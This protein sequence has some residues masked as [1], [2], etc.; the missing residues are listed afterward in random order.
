[1]TSL[2]RGSVRGWCKIC[3]DGEM[4]RHT[5]PLV[6]LPSYRGYRALLLRLYPREDGRP[7][8]RECACFHFPIKAN[9]ALTTHTPSREA[10][11]LIVGR[12]LPLEFTWTRIS[13]GPIISN[14][15]YFISINSSQTVD[16]DRSKSFLFR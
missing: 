5:L 13:R 4:K 10:C 3:F 8:E 7:H 15:W 9:L 16:C 11:H 2:T 14:T 12:V 6:G 1:M